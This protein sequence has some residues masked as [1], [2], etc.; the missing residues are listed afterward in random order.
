MPFLSPQQFSHLLQTVTYVPVLRR[1]EGFEL[2]GVEALFSGTRPVVY[3]TMV[4]TKPY[5]CGLLLVVVHG[6]CMAPPLTPDTSS[7][8]Q[9]TLHSWLVRPHADAYRWVTHSCLHTIQ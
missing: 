7:T 8:L 6:G 1:M 4:E 9:L 5:R 2:M 3:D